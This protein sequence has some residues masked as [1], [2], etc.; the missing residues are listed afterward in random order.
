MSRLALGKVQEG[1]AEIS[2]VASGVGCWW[3]AGERVQQLKTSIV[4]SGA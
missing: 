3:G 4:P 1:A 2:K